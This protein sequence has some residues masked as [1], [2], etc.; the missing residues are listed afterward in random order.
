M[1]KLLSD[2]RSYKIFLVLKYIFSVQQGADR[3]S[4]L[5]CSGDIED[6]VHNFL[7]IML[8]HSMR[9]KDGWKVDASIS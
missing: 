3:S 1:L 8:E 5:A 7:I 6:F 2:S 4:D 9:M